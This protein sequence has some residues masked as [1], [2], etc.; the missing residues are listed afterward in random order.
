MP[1]GHTIHRAA[2]DQRPMLQGK[3]LDV[4]SPQ[5]RFFEGAA[6]LDGRVCVSVDAYGKHLLYGFGGGDVLHIHLGLF[7]RFNTR[8]CPAPEPR[9]A[10]RVRMVSATHVV[11]INGPNTCE[12]LDGAG[13]AGLV[14]RIGPDVLRPDADPERAWSRIARSRAPIGQLLMDQ[15]VIAGIGNIYRSEILW[16]QRVHP[17]TP[18]R[19]IGRGAFDRLWTDAVHLLELGVKND[20][21]IT[22]DNVKKSRSRYGERVNIFG[23][24]NCPLCASDIRKFELAARRVFVCETCQPAAPSPA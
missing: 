10:V 9:G 20:A 12:V 4:S 2:R 22:V 7:G 21:I 6:R 18:G 3:T 1:E 23:K 24:P 16:R 8:K 13:L 14:A 11:D 19:E 15:S 17:G 5:G